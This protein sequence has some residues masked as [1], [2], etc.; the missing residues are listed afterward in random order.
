MADAAD[1]LAP[2]NRLLA[3]L[4][5]EELSR[6]VPHLA[7][8]AVPLAHVLHEPGD[9]I[10]ELYFPEH[11]LI[12]LVL[13]TRPETEAGIVGREGAVGAVSIL[14]V[15]SSPFRV[16]GQIAGDGLVCP[17]SLLADEPDRFPALRRLIKLYVYVLGM[18]SASTTFANAHFT[19][20][21]RLA[22]WLLMAHDRVDG[23]EL[24]LTHEFLALM[25]CVR[26]PG[27]TVATHVLEGNG[28]IRARR[29]RITVLK[30]AGLMELA[31]ASYGIAEREYDRL[32][33]PA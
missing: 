25:L 18:Q 16:V 29:G 7:H 13:P 26:R 14:G 1:K 9:P 31:G 32:I 28:I 8:R 11:G 27:V 12:S 24:G 3:A 2:R 10:A 5:R 17:A 6:L 23:D 21:Q 33:A 30:R 22:R 20:E 4:P 19:V 15:D